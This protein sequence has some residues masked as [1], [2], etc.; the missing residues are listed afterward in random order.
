MERA[1]EYIMDKNTII[2]TAGRCA[3]AAAEAQRW[4]ERNEDRVKNCGKSKE[5]VLKSLRR[6][7][8]EFR[9]LERAAG[10]RMCAGVFGPSQAGKS[11]LVGS[12]AR[13][14]HNSVICQFADRTFNF[15][16]ELNPAG[17]K[18][19]TGLV[20]RFTMTAPA[21]M[22]SG[23]P[24]H[25]RL[26][27]EAEL[28]KILANSYFRDSSSNIPPKPNMKEE[29]RTALEALKGRPSVSASHIDV[30]AMEDLHEYTQNSFGNYSRSAALDDVYWDDAIEMAPKMS[31]EDR[32]RLFSIIWDG[33]PEFTDL[34]ISLASDLARLGNP[35]E[36]FCAMDALVPRE[37]SIIDVETLQRTDFSPFGASPTVRVCSPSGQV[38]EI[39]RKNATA[40][41]A[42]LTLVITHKPAEYFTHTDLLDFPGYKNRLECSDVASY[43]RSGK[44]DGAV[45]QFFRRGKV[46]YLFQ[47]YSEEREL[48][49]LLLCVADT[50]T[51]Q[52]LGRAIQNWIIATHGETPEDRLHTK[53]ALFYVLTKSDRHFDVV[54]GKKPETLWN[55]ALEGVFLSHFGSAHSMTTRWVEEWTPGR[56]FNN[57]FLLRN[58]SF[59]WDS[60][61]NF[62]ASGR[63]LAV[64]EDKQAY[65]AQMREA[66]IGSASVQKHFASPSTAIDELLKLNDGGI[67]YIKRSLQPVCDPHLKLTQVGNALERAR[68][69]LLSTLAPFYHSGDKEEELKKKNELFGTFFNLFG[70]PL[71]RE[72]FPELLNSFKISP[73]VLFYMH[74]EAERRHREYLKKADAPCFDEFGKDGGPLSASGGNPFGENPFGSNPFGS[75]PFGSAPVNPVP[76]EPA[77]ARTKSEPEDVHS[78]YASRIIE[79]WSGKMHS[80]AETGECTRYYRFPKAILTRVLDEFDAA[81]ARL[82]LKQKLEKKFRE[83]ARPVDVSK[84]SKTHKQASYAI[85]VLNDFVSWLGKKPSDVAAHER[86][87]KCWKG[88]MPVFPDKPPVGDGPILGDEFTPYS[89]Q[90]MQDW[91]Y[92]FHGMLIENVT[93]TDGTK[94]NLEE[95]AVIGE[96]IKKIKQ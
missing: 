80:T 2:A 29:I 88:D 64:R 36:A 49:S 70:N 74:G 66:F 10:R 38:A 91:L 87:V 44:D 62:D 17:G 68:Q 92:A 20:T 24:V 3:E 96:I 59:T 9:K 40:I 7:A 47:R 85:G 23:Y 6:Q 81:A 35:K 50:T 82:E 67:E 86:R 63:E 61:L 27:S 31:L 42:E 18:E 4:I 37:A 75:N 79:A 45:E 14:E 72:R 95:N 89:L 39:S 94:I 58:I 33:I 41:I 83:I 55:N 65:V 34:F 16:R 43:L 90:W 84:D 1:K 8:R 25:V 53:N 78:F 76:A 46:D 15:I 28:V 69:T 73:E 5:D 48:T 60:M 26:F 21:N 57:L 71:F 52:G 22:P 56:A 32:A 54:A 13:D 93:F 30:D 51:V 11:Y 19:S 77:P 12:L